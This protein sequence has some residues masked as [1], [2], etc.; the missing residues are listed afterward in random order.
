MS[1]DLYGSDHDQ[2][3][4]M[5]HFGV[6]G[7]KW[8]VRRKRAS[9]PTSKASTKKRVET[10]SYKTIA[11][12]HKRG[13]KIAAAV[14]VGTAGLASVASIAYGSGKTNG[15]AAMGKRMID[16][17]D[18]IILDSPSN[19]ILAAALHTKDRLERNV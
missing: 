10:G 1:I 9:K 18:D 4:D 15:A 12:K 19:D 13:V 8:G 6:K 16:S 5:Y 11:K 7:M 17:M 2:M 14:L 3:T